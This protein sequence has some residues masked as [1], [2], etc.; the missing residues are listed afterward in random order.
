MKSHEPRACILGAKAVLHQPIPDLARGAEFGDLLKEV[1]M[2]IEE[3]AEPRTKFIDVQPAT[4]RPFHVLHAVIDRECE[5]LQCS[6]ASLA[7]V[8]SADGN[9][10]EPRREVSSKFE[11]V[12]DQPHRRGRW[13]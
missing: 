5:F 8:I 2:G 4:A 13:K 11:G 10:V 9:G 3:K 7:D 12:D 6:R 1:I